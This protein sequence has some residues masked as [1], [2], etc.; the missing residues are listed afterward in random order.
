MLNNESAVELAGVI[1]T[2]PTVE[3]A[4]VIL[5]LTASGGPNTNGDDTKQVINDAN[6]AYEN[7]GSNPSGVLKHE[8]TC[9]G[10]LEEVTVIAEEATVMEQ[11]N[12]FD[13][14]SRSLNGLADEVPKMNIAP[15]I[16]CVTI[17]WHLRVL[18]RT[19]ERQM[20]VIIAE[21]AAE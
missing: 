4:K 2:E 18:E 19:E 14:C 17:S 3:R 9:F 13:K 6:R 12:T 1:G 21:T 16:S 5:P 8:P 11:M 20:P 7:T 15:V 10:I